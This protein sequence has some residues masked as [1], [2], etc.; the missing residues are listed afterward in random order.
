MSLSVLLVEDD[1]I[2]ADL[3]RAAF[4]SLGGQHRVHHAENGAVAL[5]YLRSAGG[6]VDLI[7]TDL[8]MPVIDGIGLL[9]ALRE[10]PIL[11]SIP[12]IVLTSSPRHAGVLAAY[13]L[14]AINVFQKPE[15]LAELRALVRMMVDLV[16]KGQ[17]RDGVGQVA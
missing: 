4:V 6:T 14:Q 2:Q 13:P 9:G 15:A 3:V 5:Q 12:V 16:G 10:D 8:L 1:P 11:R 17:P 7:I